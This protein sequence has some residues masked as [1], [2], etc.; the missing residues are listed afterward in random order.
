MRVR[1]HSEN[2]LDERR[3]SNQERRTRSG[4]RRGTAY[5]IHV[6]TQVYC[7]Q[8]QPVNTRSMDA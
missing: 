7:K 2:H 5:C 8:F 6:Y 1:G 3:A 4:I